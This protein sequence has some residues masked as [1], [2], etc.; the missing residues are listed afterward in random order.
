MKLPYGI[1]PQQEA[2]YAAPVTA[3]RWPVR[4]LHGEPSFINMLDAL[5]G[6]QLVREAGQAGS[7]FLQA[8]FACGCGRLRGH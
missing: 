5:N 8:C 1:N 6:W 2:A 7:R 4:L 3:G